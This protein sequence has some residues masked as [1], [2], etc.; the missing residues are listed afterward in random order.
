MIRRPPR[1]T[2]FPY[3]TLFRS[4]RVAG[5]RPLHLRIE[6][7]GFRHREVG[8]VVHVGVAHALV[9]LDYRDRGLLDDE[10]HEVLAAARDDE[11]NQLV[12][13]EQ[14]GG[15]LAVGVVDERD[16]SGRDA[17]LLAGLT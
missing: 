17:D 9:V 10:L 8:L 16:R 13:L 1:S 2:L 14:Q 5:P 11:I 15:D 7:D 3:T 4:H 12:L 6:A